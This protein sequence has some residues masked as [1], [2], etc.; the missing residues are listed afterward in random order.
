M[1][2]NGA[3][4][5]TPPLGLLLDVDGPISSTRTR[6]VR[7]PGLAADLVAIVR[8]GCPVV[9]NTGRSVD[10]L[11]EQVLPALTRAGLVS[12]DPVFGVGEKGGT[13]FSLVERDGG[14]AVGEVSVDESIAPPAALVAAGKK[15]AAEHSDIVFFDNTKRTM[16]SLEQHVTVPREEFLPCRDEIVAAFERAIAETCADGFTIYPTVISVDVEHVNSGKALGARRALELIGERMEAPRRWFTAGDS[17]QDYDMAAYLHEH[18]FE[19]S[20]LDVR[21]AGE[22]PETPFEVIREVPVLEDGSA[23]DDITARHISR[24]RLEIGA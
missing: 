22:V 2:Q 3:V 4:T 17:G 6:T 12:T 21:L 7:L 13:W 15:I 10:F 19:V 11:A 23:E 14:P 20:H 1:R 8:A 18:G 5:S 24:L 9:F 16:L